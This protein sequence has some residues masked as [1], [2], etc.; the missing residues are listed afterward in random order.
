[1]ADAVARFCRKGL[2]AA[3]KGQAAAA[4]KPAPIKANYQENFNR[5]GLA[6]AWRK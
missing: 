6:A 1:M 3:W 2:S 4:A 5:V